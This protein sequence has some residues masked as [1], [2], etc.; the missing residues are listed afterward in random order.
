MSRPGIARSILLALCFVPGAIVTLIVEGLLGI[1]W[2]WLLLFL[3]LVPIYRIL[4]RNA[5]VDKKDAEVPTSAIL[6]DRV[7]D[8][9][10]R[11]IQ[12]ILAMLSDR[13][14]RPRRFSVSFDK[15]EVDDY[16]DRIVRY[17][18][19]QGPA[20]A[21]DDMQE[22]SFSWAIRQRGYDRSEVV[23][24]LSRVAREIDRLPVLQQELNES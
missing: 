18:Q 3:F 14:L 20:I 19:G 10:A 13:K 17:L 12:Y 24:L 8:D 7:R 21:T 5:F 1:S 2:W 15:G 16:L 23:H 9:R 11:D 22:K 4:W 6:G